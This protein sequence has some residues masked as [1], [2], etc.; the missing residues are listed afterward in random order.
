MLISISNLKTDE[1]NSV[2][3]ISFDVDESTTADALVHQVITP[4]LVSQG[5]HIS[6]VKKAY[7]EAVEDIT[8]LEDSIKDPL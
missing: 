3:S 8:A 6:S 2:N 4:L 7:Q 1:F 5:F